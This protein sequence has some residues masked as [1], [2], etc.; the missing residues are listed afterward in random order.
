MEADCKSI[1][2]VYTGIDQKCLYAG[3]GETPAVCEV[4]YITGQIQEDI[5]EIRRK[6]L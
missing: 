4:P 5:L 2:A 6:D 1:S 3:Q